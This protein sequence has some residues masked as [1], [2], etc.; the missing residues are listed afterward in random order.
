MM[1]TVIVI[2]IYNSVLSQNKTFNKYIFQNIVIV[3]FI[4][5]FPISCFNSIYLFT[6]LLHI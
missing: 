6:N 2:G 1:V 4:R 5:N 3:D